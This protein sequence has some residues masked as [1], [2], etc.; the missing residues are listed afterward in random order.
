MRYMRL[1]KRLD[2]LKR[3]KNM[4]NVIVLLVALFC[5]LG[6]QILNTYGLF[7]SSKG[8]VVESDLAKFHIKVND[9]QV[10]TLDNQFVVDS[11]K[12]TSDGNV[13]E[14]RFAPNT[15]FYFD[16]V[17]DPMDTEVAFR[18]D[19]SFDLSVF[20][21]PNIVFNGIQEVNGT[22]L[23]R[24][25]EY[26]YTGVIRL[27]EIQNGS[28]DIRIHFVWN[29]DDSNNDV[30]SQAFKGDSLMVHIPVHVKFSQYLSEEIVAYSE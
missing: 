13:L 11:L 23:V 15:S 28:R 17:I 1:F 24:T 12:I 26:T 4:K 20:D 27:D 7:E 3:I 14:N 9:K 18:Y 22:D 8:L 6:I 16:V 21:N 25:G 29:H 2:I 30:D 19:I 10:T 5:L